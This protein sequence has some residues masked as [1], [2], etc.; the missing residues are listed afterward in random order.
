MG[1]WLPGL[2]GMNGEA[3]TALFNTSCVSL[4]KRA[5]TALFPSSSRPLLETLAPFHQ[6]STRKSGGFCCGRA[7][8]SNTYYHIQPQPPKFNFL[9]PTISAQMGTHSGQLY[10]AEC[11]LEFT[12]LNF[13][14]SVG[15]AFKASRVCCFLGKW[16]FP[17]PEPQ[18]SDFQ[19]ALSDETWFCLVSACAFRVTF[20]KIYTTRYSFRLGTTSVRGIC[21]HK[22]H[23]G[24]V[25]VCYYARAVV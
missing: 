23:S 10:A 24:S 2:V 22:Y 17:P 6:S 3:C 19:A 1:Q 18:F 20:T 5:S 8:M 21:C 13:A 16:D 7:I 25:A 14:P 9:R 4:I 15:S 12:T 11:G